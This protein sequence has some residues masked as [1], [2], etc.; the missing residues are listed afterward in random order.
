MEAKVF[1]SLE[2]S[3]SLHLG[4]IDGK[5]QILIAAFSHIKGLLEQTFL[6][7]PQLVDALPV[8]I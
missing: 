5:H 8:S 3:H 2:L 1:G 7:L 4:V 6:P